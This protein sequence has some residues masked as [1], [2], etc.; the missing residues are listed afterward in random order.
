M[1]ATPVALVTGAARGQ[2]AAI[3]ARL[4]ADGF[5]IVAGDVL[6]DELH[7]STVHYGDRVVTVALDVTSEEQWAAAVAAAVDRFGTLTTLVNNAGVL[8]RA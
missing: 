7:S 6:A 3:V 2:G 5:R 8:H 4:H 1:T